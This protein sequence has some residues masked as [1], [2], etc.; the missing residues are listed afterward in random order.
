MQSIRLTS[1]LSGLRLFAAPEGVGGPALASEVAGA[2]SA[3]GLALRALAGWAAAAAA[4]RAAQS[5]P[6]PVARDDEAAL[7]NESLLARQWRAALRHPLPTTAAVTE[8]FVEVAREDG[9]DTMR[10]FVRTYVPA[11][12]RCARR[13][14]R[15]A[16]QRATT[17]KLTMPGRQAAPRGVV[18]LLHGLNGHSS[19]ASAQYTQALLV[20]RG[21]VVV[22]MDHEGHGRTAAAN[23]AQTPGFFSDAETMAGDIVCLIRETKHRYP[24]LPLFLFGISFGGC[25]A[26]LASLQ[27]GGEERHML[28]TGMVLL[29]PFILPAQASTPGLLTQLAARILGWLAPRLPIAGA[30]RGRGANPAVRGIVLAAMVS[31]TPRPRARIPGCTS[32][33]LQRLT[34]VSARRRPMTRCATLASF[35]SVLVSPFSALLS[36]CRSHSPRHARC[37]SRGDECGCLPLLVAPHGVCRADS[38][39]FPPSQINIPFLIQH[40]SAD[41]VVSMEGSLRLYQ[42]AVSSDKTLQTFEGAGHALLQELPDT[43]DELRQGFVG[44]LQARAFVGGERPNERGRHAE[45]RGTNIVQVLGG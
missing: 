32:R 20:N 3:A 8:S 13:P 34:I 10:L 39:A 31:K 2:T 40:G 12:A 36:S 27:L 19:E 9:G 24:S 35:E 30:P 17:A 14:R 16:L 45:R 33:A 26:L 5:P 42:S 37:L 38:A 11:L 22:A 41:E 4:P 43:I 7:A 6:A 25:L 29:C 1:P 44:W 18:L 15:P 21:F 28:L 23:S